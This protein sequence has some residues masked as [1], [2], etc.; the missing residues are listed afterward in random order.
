MRYGFNL[1]IVCAMALVFTGCGQKH[2]KKENVPAVSR[3]GNPIT[4]PGS[5]PP[6]SQPPGSQPPGGGASS[7]PKCPIAL[8]FNPNKQYLTNL[9]RATQYGHP[10][11]KSSAGLKERLALLESC[12]R[13][14]TILQ[15]NSR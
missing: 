9:F 15:Q 3:P 12:K 11:V 1:L 7:S 13:E 2:S 4:P 8:S 6:G 5:R 10:D 14:R